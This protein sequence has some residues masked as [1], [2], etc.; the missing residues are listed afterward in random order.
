MCI[1]SFT[2]YYYKYILG[3]TR[4]NNVLK[5]VS[6][7][8]PKQSQKLQFSVNSLTIVVDFKVLGLLYELKCFSL[9]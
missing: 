6:C 3:S 7:S 5:N 4:F 9:L 2:L 8:M 1:L